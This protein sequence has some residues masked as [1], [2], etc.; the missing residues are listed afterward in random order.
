M[1]WN[2]ISWFVCELSSSDVKVRTTFRNH[3]IAEKVMSTPRTQRID[4]QVQVIL[5]VVW[6]SYHQFFFQ[7]VTSLR[8][9][10]LVNPKC[11]S[12]VFGVYV[13]YKWG[14]L[15]ACRRRLPSGRLNILVDQVAIIID[16]V[17]FSTIFVAKALPKLGNTDNEGN[18][19]YPVALW[20]ECQ[21]C[22]SRGSGS[23]RCQVT[24]L[25]FLNRLGDFHSASLHPRILK[26]LIGCLFSFLYEKSHLW[27]LI[28]V[29]WAQKELINK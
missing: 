17:Y 16:N 1:Q 13:V 12:W 22:R 18:K 21:E 28:T 7:C 11:W 4:V 10:N 14:I 26:I 9:H 19:D 5:N 29:A 8:E 20:F 23:S 2:G 27:P 6:Q 3:W 25:R 15:A 24:V